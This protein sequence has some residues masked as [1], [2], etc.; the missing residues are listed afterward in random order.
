MTDYL[1][2]SNYLLV[3]EDKPPEK[4]EGGIFYADAWREKA[5]EGTVLAVGPDCTDKVKEGDRVIFVRHSDY[6]FEDSVSDKNNKDDKGKLPVYI[7]VQETNIILCKRAK[8]EDKAQTK[9][10]APS[11][12]DQHAW[13]GEGRCPHCVKEYERNMN[14]RQGRK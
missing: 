4:S 13:S 10:F 6:E 8:Q 11:R 2:Y 14:P 7:C 5:N 12:C 1:P 9:L 3:Q